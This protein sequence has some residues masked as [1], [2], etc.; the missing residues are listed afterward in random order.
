[1]VV[2]EK[3]LNRASVQDIVDHANVSRGTFY[4][5][6]A[7]K[8]AL[9]DAIMREGIQRSLS[10]LPM[11]SAWNR[12]SLQALIKIVLEYFKSIYQRH[13]RSRDI[14]PVIDQAIRDEMNTVILLWIKQ[15]P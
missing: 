12:Q 1:D 14:G 2:R 4:A 7:D 5:H 9:I 11:D 8:Y 13:H 3:G 15:V 10:T 6:Y